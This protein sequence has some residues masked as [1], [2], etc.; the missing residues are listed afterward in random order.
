[1]V[2][3]LLDL[4]IRHQRHD[5]VHVHLYYEELPQG[6]QLLHGLHQLFSFVI[7]KTSSFGR[8]RFTNTHLPDHRRVGSDKYHVRQHDVRRSFFL[9]LPWVA[10][11]KDGERYRCRQRYCY[12]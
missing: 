6:G 3:E 1:M 5:G 7:S 12:A 10:E 11:F 9:S 8:R 4:G 2:S